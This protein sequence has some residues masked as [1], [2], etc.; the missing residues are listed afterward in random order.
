[1]E[2]FRMNCVVASAATLV[3]AALIGTAAHAHITLEKQSA[4]ADTSYKAVLRVPHGCE[5]S[6]TVRL[7]V[8]IP[9]GV[10]NVKPQ[11]KP[12]WTIATVKEKLA[13]PAVLG[14]GREVTETIREVS[15]SGGKLPD[16][17]YDEFAFR[18]ELPDTPGKTIYF[19]VVQE[20]EKGVE[21]WIEIPQPGKS[22]RDYEKPAPELK[23]LPKRER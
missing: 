1:M 20:C 10:L 5:G 16:D 17:Y 22:R 11:P 9:D 13:T 14:H 12:G 15:W 21:R 4:P 18:V 7:R 2:M 19:P 6:A 3:S 8:R 23:L